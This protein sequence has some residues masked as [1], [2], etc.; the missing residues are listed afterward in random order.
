MVKSSFKS[1]F[2]AKKITITYI[3]PDQINMAVLFW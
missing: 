3:Q 1:G 2:G